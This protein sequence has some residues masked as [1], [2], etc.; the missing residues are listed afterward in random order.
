M[1]N[2]RK[3]SG[4]YYYHLV[5]GISLSLSQSNPIKRLI[6]TITQLKPT[7]SGDAKLSL[8]DVFFGRVRLPAQH[9]RHPLLLPAAVQQRVSR[10]VPPSRHPLSHPADTGNF[11]LHSS[12]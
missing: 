1:P 10:E 3:S 8:A 2:I 4:T 7:F 9:L 5:I 6:P 11:N 12:N